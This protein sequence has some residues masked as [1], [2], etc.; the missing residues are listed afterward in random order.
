[1]ELALSL[2]ISARPMALLPLANLWQNGLEKEPQLGAKTRQVLAELRQSLL[3]REHFRELLACNSW[4]E[5]L[6]AVQS[7]KDRIFPFSYR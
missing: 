1:V 2:G 4:Q 5:V 6:A 7:L 3:R